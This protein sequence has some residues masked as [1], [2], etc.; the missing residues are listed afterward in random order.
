M[1]DA[2]I[3]ITLTHRKEKGGLIG[4]AETNWLKKKLTV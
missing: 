4:N 2:V 3:V 1:L